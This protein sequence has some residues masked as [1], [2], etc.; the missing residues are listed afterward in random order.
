MHIQL[1]IWRT[2]E[3]TWPGRPETTGITCG[4]RAAKEGCPLQV[5]KRMCVCVWVGGWVWV[6]GCGCEC[7]CRQQHEWA[8]SRFMRAATRVFSPEHAT[9]ARG[10]HRRACPQHAFGTLSLR[11]DGI[12]AEVASCSDEAQDDNGMT[13]LLRA[14]PD[15]N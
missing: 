6:G 1:Y 4:R 7:V 5:P 12:A 15:N 14:A 9:P 2:G 10:S 3:L 13:A 8:W 11:E